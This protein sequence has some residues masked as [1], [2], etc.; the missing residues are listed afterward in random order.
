M[1]LILLLTFIT[2]IAH[3]QP[4]R[5]HPV[6]N[7]TFTPSIWSTNNDKPPLIKHTET[8]KATSNNRFKI[9]TIQQQ[10]SGVIYSFWCSVVIVYF[11]ALLFTATFFVIWL[12]QNI[13]DV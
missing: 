1:K 6:N 12:H 4:I 13:K 8:K 3:S 11:S 5:E 9:N 2:V 7:R 10:Q